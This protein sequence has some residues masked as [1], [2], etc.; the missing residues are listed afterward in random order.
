MLE[1]TGAPL[2]SVYHHFPGGKEELILAVLELTG[3]RHDRF[4]ERFRGT[5]A[6][7]ITAGYLE[8]WCGI[9]LR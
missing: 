8:P 1:H 9:L 5:S 3:L 4:V 6:E 7:E 2:G